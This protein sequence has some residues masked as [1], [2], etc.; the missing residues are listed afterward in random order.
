MGE[1]TTLWK[2]D[3]MEKKKT[4]NRFI[5]LARLHQFLKPNRFIDPQNQAI[6]RWDSGYDERIIRRV[7]NGVI[8]AN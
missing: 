1:R 6:R 5:V 2:L 3:S 8:M 4:Q 7:T